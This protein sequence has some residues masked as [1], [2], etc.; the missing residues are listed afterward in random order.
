MSRSC[1]E[2]HYNTV[3]SYGEKICSY[4]KKESYGMGNTCGFQSSKMPEHRSTAGAEQLL[5]S[6]LAITTFFP[7]KKSCTVFKIRQMSTEH[8]GRSL[9]LSETIKSFRAVSLFAQPCLGT[10]FSGGR[11]TLSFAFVGKFFLMLLGM[12]EMLGRSVCFSS[13]QNSYQ[14]AIQVET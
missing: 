4:L 9:R 11:L 3:H 6:S 10:G 2:V 5:C 14:E 7:N 8:F 13:C 1:G 12:A